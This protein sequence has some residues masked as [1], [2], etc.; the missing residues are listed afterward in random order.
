MKKKALLLA[1]ILIL[2]VGC[3]KQSVFSLHD[4]R[5]S[6]W[7]DSVEDVRKAED[8]EPKIDGDNRITYEDKFLGYDSEFTYIFLEDKLGQVSFTIRC[9]SND[10]AQS[11]F[12]DIS[13]QLTSAYGQKAEDKSSDTSYMYESKDALVWLHAKDTVVMVDFAIPLEK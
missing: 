4:V 7:N 10:A 3:G 5:N 11:A 1:I 12:E 9:E 6:D 13:S 8:I 2:L